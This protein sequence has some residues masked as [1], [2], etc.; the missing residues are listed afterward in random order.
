MGEILWFFCNIS[1]VVSLEEARLKTGEKDEKSHRHL[2]DIHMNYS[3]MP[4]SEVLNTDC[5][6]ELLHPHSYQDHSA[7]R[8]APL[9]C[10][11]GSH[12]LNLG[13]CLSWSY[14]CHSLPILP[15]VRSFSLYP[16]QVLALSQ[17]QP[18]RSAFS[19]L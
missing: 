6:V 8:S 9:L 5:Q 14:L 18:V 17:L 10:F 19:S 4:V 1:N 12:T 3:H 2:F 13:L 11:S 7:D 16:S 15:S